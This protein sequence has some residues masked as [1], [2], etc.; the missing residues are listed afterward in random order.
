VTIEESGERP[1]VALADLPQHPAGRL[2]DKVFPV[3]DQ[4]LGDG[5]RLCEIAAANREERREHGDAARP[6]G[7]RTPQTHKCGAPLA[8]EIPADDMRG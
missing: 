6:Q 1:P 3:V 2:L 7:P 4:H 5:E 8:I